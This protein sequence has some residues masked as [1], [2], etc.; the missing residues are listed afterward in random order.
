MLVMPMWTGL[1]SLKLKNKVLSL[2]LIFFSIW[3]LW[4]K[5]LS[6]FVVNCN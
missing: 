6:I 2:S 3:W 5:S 4:F 1:E